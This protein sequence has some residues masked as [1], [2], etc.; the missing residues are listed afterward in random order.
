VYS[1]WLV[2]SSSSKD[3][4]KFLVREGTGQ[5]VDMEG[6]DIMCALVMDRK[7]DEETIW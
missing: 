1:N 7:Q 3:G 4:N 6:R 2:S 5:G